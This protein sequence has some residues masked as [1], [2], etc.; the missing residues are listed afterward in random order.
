LCLFPLLVLFSFSAL[1]FS[2]FIVHV[3]SF[4]SFSLSLH[5]L[6]PPLHSAGSCGPR[7]ITVA[8]CTTVALTWFLFFCL[9][10]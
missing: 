8:M 6:L 4:S 7:G 10:L 5:P 2:T 3:V 1:T 9:R